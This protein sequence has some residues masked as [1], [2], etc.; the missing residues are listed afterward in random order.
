MVVPTGRTVYRA[1]LGSIYRAL[2]EF[3]GRGTVVGVE[4]LGW[5]KPG[6]I[7]WIGDGSRFFR[8]FNHCRVEYTQSPSISNNFQ[9]SSNEWMTLQK[10]ASRQHDLW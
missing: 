10:S 2:G 4:H 5:I 3:P 9:P 7:C 8:G 1:Y 6:W